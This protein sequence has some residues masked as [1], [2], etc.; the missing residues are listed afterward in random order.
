MT[1]DECCRRRD[2]WR[3]A[4]IVVD[5]VVAGRS[6]WTPVAALKAICQVYG[7]KRC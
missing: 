4:R 7:V 5:D 3:L 2:Y 1:F 6:Q